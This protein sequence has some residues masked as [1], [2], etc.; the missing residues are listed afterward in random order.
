MSIILSLQDFI[1][2][3][4]NSK[5]IVGFGDKVKSSSIVTIEFEVIASSIN[6]TSSGKPSLS[7]NWIIVSE[8]VADNTTALLLN[9]ERSHS[10]VRVSV[11]VVVC[12]REVL[13][14]EAYEWTVDAEGIARNIDLFIRRHGATKGENSTLPRCCRLPIDENGTIVVAVSIILIGWDNGKGGIS[15]RWPSS[16]RGV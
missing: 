5:S 4:I 9:S 2:V 7:E 16:R 1:L 6:R 15:Q 8:G 3:L 11:L 12:G 13:Y 10:P 14:A